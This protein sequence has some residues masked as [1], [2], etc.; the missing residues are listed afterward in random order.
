MKHRFRWFR[1]SQ[2]CLFGMK[3]VMNKQAISKSYGFIVRNTSSILKIIEKPG[4]VKPLAPFLGLGIYTAT[5]DVFR[6]I[7][8]TPASK[9]RNE[10]EWT[11]TLN[12]M[13]GDLRAIGH[14]LRGRYV[15]VNTPLDLE[16]I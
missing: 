4:D 12:L 1:D 11:D 9:L 13:A 16:K 2:Y 5:K 6:Y 7:A 8:K 15:N 14:I 10:V 3:P